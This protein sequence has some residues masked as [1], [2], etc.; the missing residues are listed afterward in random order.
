MYA[1]LSNWSLTLYVLT[2]V[3]FFA[4]PIRTFTRQ[5]FFFLLCFFRS[6]IPSAPL[7]GRVRTV[8]VRFV[9]FSSNRHSIS[10]QFSSLWKISMFCFFYRTFVHLPMRPVTVG[11][12]MLFRKKEKEF[13]E[14][15]FGSIENES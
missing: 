12:R 10:P 1:A 7:R 11:R 14:N 8:R 6:I 3:A 15:E 2:G 5:F 13:V 9:R 4:C